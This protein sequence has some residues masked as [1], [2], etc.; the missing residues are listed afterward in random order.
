MFTDMV[1]EAVTRALTNGADISKAKMVVSSKPKKT[2]LNDIL[3]DPEQFELVAHLE[4]DGIVMRIRRR[5]EES[6][7]EVDS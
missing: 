1:S 6:S 4:R 5:K 3:T 7:N 2:V